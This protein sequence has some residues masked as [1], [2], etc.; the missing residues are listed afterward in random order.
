MTLEG[1]PVAPY[2]TPAEPMSRGEI[3]VQLAVNY[4]EDLKLRAL[5]RYGRE[6]R[7]C[8]DLYVQMICYC[9]RNLTDGFVPAEE[10]GV[11]V[12]P[13]SLKAGRRDADRLVEVGLAEARDGGYFVPGFLKRNKSKAEVDAISAAKAESGRRGGIRSGQVRRSEANAKQGASQ[14]ANQSASEDEANAKQGAS[15]R[16]NTEVIGHR[17]EN[18]PPTAGADKPRRPRKDPPSDANIGTVVAAYVD[19][20]TTAGQPPPASSLKARVGKQ[21]RQLLADGYDIAALIE[22]AKRMGAGEWNDLAVQVRKDSAKANGSSSGG[23]STGT[24]RARA[25]IEAGQRVQAMI[26]RGELPS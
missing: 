25:A 14:G 5:A 4:A 17:S 16:L 15:V 6:A 20:A 22:S 18:I 12:Y 8:R 19:G 1:I 7:G 13:D 11:L 23:E 9:K 2:P 10:L 24:Q 3:H 26:D 21:A